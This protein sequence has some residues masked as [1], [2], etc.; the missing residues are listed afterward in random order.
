MR[1][2]FLAAVPLLTML[3]A[4]PAGAQVSARLHVDVPIGRQPMVGY[5]APRNQLVIRD[6]DERRFG[7]WENYYDEWTPETVYLYDGYYYDYP[8]VA[9]A[10][11]I[12]VYRYR[13]E[14]FFAPRQREFIQWRDQRGFRDIGRAYRPIPRNDRDDRR[15]QD[16][17]G[18]QAPRGRDGG[19]FRPAPQQD[20]RNGRD[21]RP[22]PRQ[23]ERNGRDARPAP[24]GGRGT[25]PARGGDRSRPHGH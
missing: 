1:K 2:S 25:P 4:L 12:V 21:A 10:Q 19:Q 23:D 7:L 8:I 22:A 6:Y 16:N 5:G 9:Y 18:F 24:Q 14:M 17:R 11:P 15:F 3:S 20:D 13:N